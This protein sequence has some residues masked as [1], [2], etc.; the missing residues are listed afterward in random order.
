MMKKNYFLEDTIGTL[1]ENYDATDFANSGNAFIK[2]WLELIRKVQI[3]CPFLELE[4]MMFIM[5]A[6]VV[7]EAMEV[8]VGDVVLP[9]IIVTKIY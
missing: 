2:K 1:F 6:I 9:V 7:M 4:G 3:R 5:V 8:M